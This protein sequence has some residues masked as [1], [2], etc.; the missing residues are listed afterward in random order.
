MEFNMQI[1][2]NS[3]NFFL[4]DCIAIPLE[5]DSV[6]LVF[7]SPPYEDA[8]TYGIDFLAKGDEWVDWCLP[9]M[10][11]CLRISRGVVAWVLTGR[12]RNYEYS[13][14]P[15]KLVAALSNADWCVVRK[16]C[17]YKR[18]GI[19]GTGGPDWF[20]ADHETIVCITSGGKLGWSDN[21]ACGKKTEKRP[22]RLATNRNTDGSRK[23]AVYKDPERSNP[24][25]VVDCGNAGSSMGVGR[26][27]AAQNEAPFPEALAERF[28]KSFC[29]PGGVVFDP[30]MGSG[31]TAAV[32][33]MQGRIPSGMDIRQSQI[34]LTIAR[35]NSLDNPLTFRSNTSDSTSTLFQ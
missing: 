24:G 4:G 27:F 26:N 30:F 25:D 23:S 12:T 17:I 34:D 16:P 10:Q 9:R 3:Y 2:G 7:G 19:P 14:T 22:D 29:P 18:Q 33:K 15:E 1:G 8:R 28:V 6:D 5:D 13:C 32:C 21:T 20:R 31:T 35:L 11:E